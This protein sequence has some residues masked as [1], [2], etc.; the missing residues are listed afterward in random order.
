MAKA[1]IVGKVVTSVAEG[2]TPQGTA[3]KKF[4]ISVTRGNAKT[5]KSSFYGVILYGKLAEISVQKG[6]TICVDGKMSIE[7]FRLDENNKHLVQTCLVT[8]KRLEILSGTHAHQAKAYNVLG[9]LTKDAEII[10]FKDKNGNTQNKMIKNSIAVNRKVGEEKVADFYDLLLFGERGE[11]LVQY[12]TKGKKILVDGWLQA[13]YYDKKDG[14]GKGLN[15][16]I[17]VDDLEFA[18]GPREEGDTNTNAKPQAQP[19]T[20]E[21]PEIDDEEIP[22]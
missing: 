13:E 16:S 4:G 2:A 8:P 1:R 12:L 6:Q 9:N 18:C 17:T 19:Q 11:K 21:I 7:D 14:S 22:F 15:V 3:F 5:A 20:P 10:E